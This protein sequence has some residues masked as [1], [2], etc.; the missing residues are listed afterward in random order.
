MFSCSLLKPNMISALN[1]TMF[2]LCL[3]YGLDF[4]SVKLTNASSK[5]SSKDE[6][7]LHFPVSNLQ[8]LK[9]LVV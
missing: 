7:T 3:N 6:S 9:D 5:L 8:K 2:W 1:R 4:Y